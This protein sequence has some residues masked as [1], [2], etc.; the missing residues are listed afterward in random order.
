MTKTNTREKN[1]SKRNRNVLG[2]SKSQKDY[3]KTADNINTFRKLNESLLLS[4]LKQT[5]KDLNI[6]NSLE[7][8]IKVK[9][10][11]FLE[12]T[13]KLCNKNIKR[14]Q[15]NNKEFKNRPHIL[16]NLIKIYFLIILIDLMTTKILPYNK[17]CLIIS[18]FSTI[19]L[20]INGTGPKNILGHNPDFYFKEDYYPEEVFINGNKQKEL[21]YYYIF[22]D[23][24][25]SVELRWSTSIN[26]CE[27]MFISCSNISEIDMSY[28]DT[29]QVTAMSSMFQGCTL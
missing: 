4:K 3:S 20:K 5:N 15:T 9:K 11:G 23:S 13:K 12:G 21:N 1:F 27:Y 29:S 28:F 25:N 7:D 14:Y 8:E 26:N 24:Y 18:H 2:L 10:V 22:N 6:N 16:Y 17:K 19:V